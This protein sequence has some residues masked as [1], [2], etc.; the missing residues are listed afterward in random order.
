[1]YNDS[2]THIFKQGVLS[3]KPNTAHEDLLHSLAKA[4]VI[5][6]GINT[7]SGDLA[8][9]RHEL[10]ELVNAHNLKRRELLKARLAQKERTWCTY[11]GKTIM[12]LGVSQFIFV[13]GRTEE[14]CGYENSC[15]R[16]VEFA[17][18]HRACSEC[19][20]SAFDRHGSIGAY[21]H[22]AKEQSYFHAFRV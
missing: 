16:F 2:G 19:A 17:N 9:Q 1:M 6:Q 8:S 3:M 14:S 21:N 20:E 13:E 15:Y 10:K 5:A 7:A 12:P 4:R 18:L 22:Q 11:C